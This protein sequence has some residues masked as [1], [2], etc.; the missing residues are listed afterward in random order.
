MPDEFAQIDNF[1]LFP[2]PLFFRMPSNTDEVFQDLLSHPEKYV[3]WELSFEHVIIR[4]NDI[5]NDMERIKAQGMT[6]DNVL[7]YTFYAG[8]KEAYDQLLKNTE[9]KRKVEQ[10]QNAT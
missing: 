9:I 5:I 2:K 8:M 10:D 3:N 7:K 6:K 4:R 1:T